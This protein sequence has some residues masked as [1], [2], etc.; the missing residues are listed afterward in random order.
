[1]HLNNFD[2][3]ISTYMH[4]LTLGINKSQEVVN[5]TI[6]QLQLLGLDEKEINEIQSK[7]RITHIK[8]DEQPFA[9]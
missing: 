6:E 1:M 4:L 2:F 8:K 7:F 9:S 5:K 3:S